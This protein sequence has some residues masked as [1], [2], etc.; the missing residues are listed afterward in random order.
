MSDSELAPQNPD[1][2]VAAMRKAAM[3]NL[4]TPNQRGFLV[5]LPPEGEILITGDIH[6]NL[7]NLRRIIKLADLQNHPRRHLV[8]QELVHELDSLDEICKS[9]RL[10]EIAA[11]LKLA[12]PSRVHILLGNHEFAEILE[13]G[14]GKNG[15]ALNAA[16]EDGLR[17]SYG[18]RWK[19]AKDGLCGFWRS[20]PLA[21]RT[22]NRLFISHSTPRKEMV[23]HLSLDF[24]KKASP[25]EVFQRDGAVFSMLWDRDYQ[26]ETAEAVAARMD[27]DL[28]IVGHTAC[29]EGRRIPNERHI[30]LDSKDFEA[31]YLL[32]PLDSPVSQDLALEHLHR[33]YADPSDD[34]SFQR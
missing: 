16:F 6:G 21:I 10:V 19:E 27:A 26:Q 22:A 33:L 29:P 9:H 4:A 5:E 24:F 8:L 14:I 12:V 3:A 2:L 25:A 13:L 7:A 32:L 30:I 17:L 23:E 31:R 18:D 1:A 11:K 34:I 15:R 28:L 20:C